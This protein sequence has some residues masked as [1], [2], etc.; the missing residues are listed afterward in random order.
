[1]NLLSRPLLLIALVLLAGCTK[2]EAPEPAEAPDTPDTAETTI[3]EPELTPTVPLPPADDTTEVL[4][5]TTPIVADTTPFDVRAQSRTTTLTDTSGRQIIAKI[6]EVN[7]ASL[8]IVRANEIRK[9]T[10]PFDLLSDRDRSFAQYLFEQKQQAADEVDLADFRFTAEITVNSVK[11]LVAAAKKSNQKI[12]MAPGVYQMEDYLSPKVISETD[13]HPIMGSAMITLSGDGN[14][15]DFT[16]VTIEVNTELLNDFGQKVMEFYLTGSGNLIKGLTVTNIGTAP[17]ARGGQ[18]F[19]VGGKD[20]T[21]KNVTLNVSGSSP[22]GYGDLLGKGGGALVPLRKHSGM[23]ITGDTIKILDCSIYSKSFGHLFFIQGGRDVYF[24]NCY[25]EAETRTTDEMLAETSGLAFDRDFAAVY[26]NYDRKKVITP[27]YT[28]S[29]AECG[30]RMYGKGGAKQRTTGAVTLV[31][32]RAKYCRV[33]FAMTRFEGDIL[34]QDCEA[35]ACESGYNINGTTIKNSRGDAVNG[36]LLYINAGDTPCEV[37]LALMPTLNTTTLH[38]IAC[39]AGDDH[40]VTLTNWQDTAR[41][42]LDP[43]RLGWSR[44]VATNPFSPMGTHRTAKV[45]LNNFTGM[46]VEV[47]ETVSKSTIKSNGP[48]NDQG[49]GNRVSKVSNSSSQR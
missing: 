10:I 19:V 42:Q 31:N 28:K 9:L 47:A 14:F 18:S 33:G 15:F 6:V 36:P 12:T 49:A 35:I 26:S 22:Y 29:L 48:V 21:L 46:P 45:T 40:V 3:P 1:M 24:E 34:I 7:E 20:N 32:C 8:Q 23:L 37:E 27:G 25:A 13:A 2:N 11:A 43:I 41:E 16:G 39:I 17:T 44:P 38:A 5:T 4:E 30:F